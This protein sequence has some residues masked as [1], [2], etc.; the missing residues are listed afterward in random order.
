[1]QVYRVRAGLLALSVLLA[2]GLAAAQVPAGQAPATQ[3]QQLR[4]QRRERIR[5]RLRQR[6]E[7]R[8][9]QMDVN[10]DGAISRDEWKRNTTAFD[11]F[12][13]NHDGMLTQD[14]LKTAIA[15]AVRKRVRQR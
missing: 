6:V 11:R 15:R 13:V 3:Q 5:E 10:H 4:Q 12:D 2:P 1:M 14:E 7:A 8:F 9:Q